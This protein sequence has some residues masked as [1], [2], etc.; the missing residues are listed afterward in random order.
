[1]QGSFWQLLAAS[2]VLGWGGCELCCTTLAPAAF[3]G[4]APVCPRHGVPW[5]RALA[6]PRG[7][8]APHL[9]PGTCRLQVGDGR[10]LGGAVRAAGQEIRGRQDQP[11]RMV[12]VGKTGRRARVLV[13]SANVPCLAAGVLVGSAQRPNGTAADRARLPTAPRRP[14]AQA[15]WH[16]MPSVDAVLCWGGVVLRAAGS[17]AGAWAFSPSLLGAAASALVAG[18]GQSFTPETGTSSLRQSIS[19][20]AS[21]KTSPSTAS[22]GAGAGCSRKRWASPRRTR[23]RRISGSL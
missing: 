19:K 3:V 15:Q 17:R 23:G 1:M 9:M 5:P 7:A 14:R 10:T 4:P 18:A 13:G 20:R 8:A 2:G 22:C 16:G 21:Q 12:D 11:E 6:W